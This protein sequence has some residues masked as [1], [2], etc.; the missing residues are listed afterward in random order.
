MKMHFGPAGID[1]S[2]NGKSEEFPI[3]LAEKGLSAYEY[4]CGHG[5]SIG[6]DLAQKLGCNAR[7]H[8]I[9]L[10]LHA[11]YYISL[12]NAGK[13]KENIDYIRKSVTAA[14]WMGGHKIVVHTGAIMSMTRRQALQNAINTIK[15]VLHCADS[16]GWP[17]VAI[18]LE[19][20]G[21]IGQLG[22]LAEV[23]ALC[24]ADERLIPCIDFGHLYA[25]THGNLNGT[26]K[27]SGMLDALE[28]TL[29]I[30]RAKNCHI[31]FS[32]IEFT[33]GGEKQHL[34]FAQPGEFGPDWSD[35]CPLLR[36]REYASTVICESRGTQVEDA[37]F[38]RKIAEETAR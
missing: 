26:A 12:T 6:Q 25:R 33:G 28:N 9:Q 13:L 14:A 7:Q 3:F 22:D 10:S 30:E 21:K 38:M 31:H 36:E 11:P 4:Q 1:N 20:M 16:E 24:S 17:E 5:V 34:T 23:L 2:Y 35:L 18:C 19:T 8:G 15:E 32:V 29:G 37:V 27:F